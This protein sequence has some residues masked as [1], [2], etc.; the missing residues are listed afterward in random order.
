MTVLLEVL[1]STV[2]E[3]I[4]L[5]LVVLAVLRAWKMGSIFESHRSYWQVR[6]GLLGELLGC[7]L[8]LSYHVALYCEVVFLIPLKIYVAAWWS[9]VFFPLV[10]FAAA[11]IAQTV[12]FAQHRDVQ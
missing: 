4:L 1:A 3:A 11:A 12:W 7:P 5:S 6:K 2:L 10:V 8:C 9:I